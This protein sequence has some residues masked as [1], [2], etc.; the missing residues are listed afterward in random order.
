MKIREIRASVHSSTIAVPLLKGKV[1]GYGREEQKEFV[2]C[3]V[4]TDDGLSGL[5]ITGHFLARSVVVAL[6]SY[7]LPVVRDPCCTLR[8]QRSAV[9]WY[10]HA[11]RPEKLMQATTDGRHGCHAADNEAQRDLARADGHA[12]EQ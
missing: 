3:E 2:F 1:Q 11:L 9:W 5:A 4:E 10:L 12:V 7:L 8:Y 6:R